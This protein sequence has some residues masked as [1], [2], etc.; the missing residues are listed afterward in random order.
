[1]AESL[2]GRIL[3]LILVNSDSPFG[4]ELLRRATSSGIFVL[5]FECPGKKLSF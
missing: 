2:D 1:M 3:E 5:Y 4:G